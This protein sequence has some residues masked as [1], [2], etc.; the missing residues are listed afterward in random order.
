MRLRVRGRDGS[1][2]GSDRVGSDTDSDMDYEP[3]TLAR[4]HDALSVIT[5]RLV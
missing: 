4:M 2:A 3:Q 1:E 5:E